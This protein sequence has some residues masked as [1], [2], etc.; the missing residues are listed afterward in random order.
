[1]AGAV[2]ALQL[3]LAAMLPLADAGLEATAARPD[4]VVSAPGDDALGQRSHD[5]KVCQFC[6][7]LGQDALMATGTAR[8]AALAEPTLPPAPAAPE[9]LTAAASPF[10]LGSRA[11]PRA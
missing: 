6:R 4:V 1:M 7:L 11:P 2:F 10:P 5:H 3:L 9:A 8:T